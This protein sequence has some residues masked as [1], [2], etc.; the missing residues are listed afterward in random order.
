MDLATVKTDAENNI[1]DN[2]ITSSVSWIGLF[3]DPNLFWSDASDVI[4]TVWDS[5]SNVISSL[6]VMCGVTSSGSSGKWKFKSC[7]T[8]LPFVCYSAKGEFIVLLS[9]KT[10]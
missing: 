9:W 1:L 10:C 8:R 2:K 5:V 7:E 6:Q 3:R 4:F